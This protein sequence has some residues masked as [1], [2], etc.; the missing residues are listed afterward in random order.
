M[1]ESLQERLLGV[2][3]QLYDILQHLSGDAEI[4]MDLEIEENPNG[5]NPTPV[6]T[7]SY[8]AAYVKGKEVQFRWALVSKTED[9]FI[10]EIK[11]YGL[12]CVD[13]VANLM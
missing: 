1:F 12:D 10:N 13:A 5:G 9:D 7:Y 6:V 8:R 4:K 3:E 2:K 11:A